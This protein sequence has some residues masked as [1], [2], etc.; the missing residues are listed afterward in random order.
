MEFGDAWLVITHLHTVA[1]KLEDTLKLILMDC[2]TLAMVQLLHNVCHE[3]INKRESPL[4]EHEVLL[5][6]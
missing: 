3:N 1:T 5:W 4:S 6:A 2:L